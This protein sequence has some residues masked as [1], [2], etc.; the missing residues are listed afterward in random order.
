MKIT[1]SDRRA[2]PV[3][4]ALSGDVALTS[5]GAIHLRFGNAH[6][7]P[8]GFCIEGGGAVI[9]ID[10][11]LVGPGKKADYIFVTHAHPDHFSPTD[12]ENLSGADTR[13]VCPKRVAGRLRGDHAVLEI[14]PGEAIDLGN[15]KCEAV[16]A[17]TRG[18]PSHPR[19]AGN[20]GYV[21]TVGGLRVYHAGDTHLVPEMRALQN[22]DVALVPIDGGALTMSTRDAAD[23]VNALAPRLAIPMHYAVGKNKAEE[24]KDLI[25]ARIEVAVLAP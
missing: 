9:Y 16:P 1:V 19:R 2:T 18:F 12:I 5:W 23:F 20:V 17:Y 3:R 11:V 24:F 21:L 13:I 15:L 22:I 7:L 4:V 6:L 8:S 25:D 14:R 10:P